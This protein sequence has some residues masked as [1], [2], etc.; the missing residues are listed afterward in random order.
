LYAETLFSIT[1]EFIFLVVASFTERKGIHYAIEAFKKFKSKY[2]IT[3]C[4]LR[5]IGDGPYL[6]ILIRISDNDEDIV[7]VNNFIVEKPRE[8]ILHEMQNCDVFILT[9]ITVSDSDK[10]GTPVVLMEAQ[11]CGK[12]C[13]STFHAGIPEVVLHNKT[14]L[15]VKEKDANSIANAMYQFY[16]DSKLKNFFG[17]NARFQIEKEFN[18]SIQIPELF[19]IYK[20]II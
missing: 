4:K 15:L 8:L 10:E 18:N 3:N 9:S 19:D 17:E 11:A 13:I 7:F 16:S 20:S 12:P 2:M 14:G 5:I 6:E 1:D